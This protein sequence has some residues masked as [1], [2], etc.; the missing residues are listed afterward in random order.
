M[1]VPIVMYCLRLF[2]FVVQE[3]HCL[4]NNKHGVVLVITEFYQYAK[5]GSSTVSGY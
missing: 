5:F 1:H 3:L 2:I 4:P